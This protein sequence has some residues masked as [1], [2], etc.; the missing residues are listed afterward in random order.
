VSNRQGDGIV[1]GGGGIPVT[2][3]RNEGGFA[4]IVPTVGEEGIGGDYKD[5]KA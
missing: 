4:V 1:G 5:G 3:M 2:E